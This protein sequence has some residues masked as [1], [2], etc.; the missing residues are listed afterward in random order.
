MSFQDSDFLFFIYIYPDVGLLEYMVLIVV[1]VIFWEL[2]KLFSIVAEP[3]YS[4]PT[5]YKDSIFF[6]S[7]PAFV[8]SFNNTHFNNRCEMMSLWFWFAFSWWLVMLNIFSYACRSFEISLEKCL[9]SSTA[10]FSGFF[11][12]FFCDWVVV[13]LHI[14]INNPYQINNL[15]I[16]FSFCR[17]LFYFVVLCVFLF[18]VFFSTM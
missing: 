5:E 10:N 18:F 15:Q 4:A 8:I 3:I 6:T 14:L 2:S 1:F 17:L 11:F 9:F 16:F 7:L 13:C 12:F